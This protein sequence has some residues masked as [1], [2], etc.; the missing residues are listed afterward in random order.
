[1]RRAVH[2]GTGAS[3]ELRRSCS[4]P[5]ACVRATRRSSRRLA[6]A[7]SCAAR[8]RKHRRPPAGSLG[9]SQTLVSRR[10]SWVGIGPRDRIFN[11]RSVR[12]DDS[13]HA[14]GQPVRNGHGPAIGRLWSHRWFGRSRWRFA[15]SEKFR[16]A[17]RRSLAKPHRPRSPDRRVRA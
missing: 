8:S 1:M 7:R 12:S 13:A 3:R 2:P 5:A 9:K 14:P 15:R 10:A 17:L 6:G 4:C 16:S 11:S